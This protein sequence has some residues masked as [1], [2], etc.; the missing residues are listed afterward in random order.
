MAAVRDGEKPQSPTNIA[1][2]V[3]LAGSAR[4]FVHRYRLISGFA[5]QL[6]EQVCVAVPLQLSLGRQ[7]DQEEG[8]QGLLKLYHQ[9]FARRRPQ[10]LQKNAGHHSQ[11]RSFLGHEKRHLS[12]TN[13][14][15]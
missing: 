10:L 3:Y 9:L 4:T 8:K 5:K 7:P 11:L 15:L 6:G 14:R 1:V 2:E 12:V 13:T